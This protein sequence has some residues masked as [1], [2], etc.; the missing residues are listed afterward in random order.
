MT[1]IRLA[2]RD[3]R[4][5]VETG[6]RLALKLNADGLAP[7]VTTCAE[8]G[9]V[10]M[11]A[12]TNLDALART[13]ET[14]EAHYWSR[15]RQEIWHKG[16]TSGQIQTVVDVR[17]DCDQDSLWFVV[18]QAGGGCCH[19]GYRSCFY[20]RLPVGTAIEANTIVELS[21]AE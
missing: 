12:W 16:A 8:S 15:S 19:V 2:N 20:R 10:L 9:D 3:D 14:G 17:I 13:L 7:V 18:R 1:A 21:H 6:D 4:Q 11:Q 5:M